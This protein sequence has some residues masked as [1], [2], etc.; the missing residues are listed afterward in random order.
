[1]HFLSEFVGAFPLTK[2]PPP[3]PLPDVR[4]SPAILPDSFFAAFSSLNAQLGE[5]VKQVRGSFVMLAFSVHEA[6]SLRSFF[7]RFKGA[8]GAYQV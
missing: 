3:P 4:T 8:S 2:A 6:H 1:M 7:S 5:A